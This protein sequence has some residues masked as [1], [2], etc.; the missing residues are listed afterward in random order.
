MP[1]DDLVW[2]PHLMQKLIPNQI[3]CSLGRCDNVTIRVLLFT[4]CGTRFSF[5]LCTLDG[6]WQVQPD[7]PFIGRWKAIACEEEFWFG[8]SPENLLSRTLTLCGSFM[9]ITWHRWSIHTREKQRGVYAM[10]INIL[11][12]V[13]DKEFNRISSFVDEGRTK[14]CEQV[15]WFGIPCLMQEVPSQIICSLGRSSMWPLDWGHSTLMGK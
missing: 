4:T 15:I 1:P 9:Y 5:L 7:L 10:N 2:D 11:L 12:M 8:I 13:A 14:A 6:R 3:V